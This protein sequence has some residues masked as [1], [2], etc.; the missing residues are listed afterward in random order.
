MTRDTKFKL[1]FDS[2]IKDVVG[3]L[4]YDLENLTK[5]KSE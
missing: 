1:A 5:K 2:F 4:D 3:V